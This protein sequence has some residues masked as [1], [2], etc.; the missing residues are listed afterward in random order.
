MVFATAACQRAPAPQNVIL[1]DRIETTDQLFDLGKDCPI[2]EPVMKLLSDGALHRRVWEDTLSNVFEKSFKQQFL[3]NWEKGEEYALL[4][5][6][7]I[8]DSPK[9]IVFVVGF[10]NESLGEMQLGADLTEDGIEA[11]SL[12][13]MRNVSSE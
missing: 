1:A 4:D 12:L 11:Y 9:E 3:E 13:I 2:E 7:C 8:D 6:Y 10:S 5:L